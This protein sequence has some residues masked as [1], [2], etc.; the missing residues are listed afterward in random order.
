MPVFPDRVSKNRY[1][2]TD[3]SKPSSFDHIRQLLNR[4]EKQHENELNHS[5]EWG[6]EN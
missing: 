1:H 2:L 5:I 6:G 4:E 3:E